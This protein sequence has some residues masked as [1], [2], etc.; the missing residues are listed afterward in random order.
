MSSTDERHEKRARAGAG[1]ES[2]TMGGVTGTGLG[3]QKGEDERQMH[4]ELTHSRW[5]C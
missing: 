4:G 3:S 2:F 1:I 5:D